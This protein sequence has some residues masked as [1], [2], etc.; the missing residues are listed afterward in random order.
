MKS[1]HSGMLSE[2]GFVEA[3]IVLRWNLNT[4]E[5]WDVHNSEGDL[6][7]TRWN[8]NTVECWD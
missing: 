4:V 6:P 8:L 7:P 5:C 2:R 3:I 1:K